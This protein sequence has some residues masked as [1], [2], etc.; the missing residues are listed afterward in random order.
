MNTSVRTLAIGAERAAKAAEDDTWKAQAVVL[1]G[2]RQAMLASNIANAD[3]PGYTARDLQ[4]SEALQE[5]ERSAASAP[6]AASSS[7]HIGKTSAGLS[8]VDLA[9]YSTQL[10]PS[11]D[12]NSTEE[13]QQAS[14]AKNAILLELALMTFGDELKEFKAAAGST[15]R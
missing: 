9:R 14:M 12:G 4:F 15:A 7:G 5:A 8:T 13:M 3:T 6:L 1:R 10:Q 11:L 2:R